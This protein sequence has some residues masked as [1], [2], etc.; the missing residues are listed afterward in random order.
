MKI[1]LKLQEAI[2]YDFYKDKISKDI[3]DKIISHDPTNNKGNKYSRWLVDKFIT[4]EISSSAILPM[5]D[6]YLSQYD[7]YKDSK[8]FPQDKK[9]IFKFKSYI[10]LQK[11]VLEDMKH[12]I[13]EEM[14]NLAYSE[15]E[16]LYRQDEKIFL[17]PKTHRSAVFFGQNTNWCTSNP[18][19]SNY[20]NRYTSTGTLFIFRYINNDGYPQDI[21]NDDAIQMYIPKE[22][23]LLAECRDKEDKTIYGQRLFENLDGYEN[24]PKIKKILQIWNSK[25]NTDQWDEG[26]GYLDPNELSP[27][28]PIQSEEV[29]GRTMLVENT[30]Q[31]RGGI[32]RTDIIIEEYYEGGGESTVDSDSCSAGVMSFKDFIRETRTNNKYKDLYTSLIPQLEEDS[33][34]VPNLLKHGVV[35]MYGQNSI[36]LRK[37]SNMYLDYSVDEIETA[38]NSEAVAS[39][40]E[41]IENKTEVDSILAFVAISEN[42]MGSAL[43]RAAE[44]DIIELLLEE[45]LSNVNFSGYFVDRKSIVCASY[46]VTLY[47]THISGGNFPFEIIED[48]MKQINPIYKEQFNSYKKE[49]DKELERFKNIKSKLEERKKKRKIRVKLGRPSEPGRLFVRDVSSIE[50]PKDTKK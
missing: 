19:S 5:M 7:N 50:Q 44:H 48:M 31:L 4:N 29:V 21:G 1:V 36:P 42:S 47:Y 18:N 12:I 33:P 13:E 15:S 11:F 25:S 46:W 2:N 22:D 49:A 26:T 41:K 45:S 39:I 23:D 24:M 6:T 34:F 43:T 17:I 27:E 38:R 10:D 8:I 32:L 14:K 30:A 40:L 28:E 20:Y 35:L 3:F 16:V 37:I 9:D